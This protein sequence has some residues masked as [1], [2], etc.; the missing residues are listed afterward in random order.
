MPVT[1]V[2]TQHKVSVAR[3]SAL[4]DRQPTYGLVADVDLV[5]IRYDD[6]VSVLYGRCLHRGALMADAKIDGGN[7]VCGVHGWDYRVDTGVSSYN[8]AEVLQ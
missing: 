8:N 6:Q 3:W 4:E 7:I 5:I 1:Q 2:R